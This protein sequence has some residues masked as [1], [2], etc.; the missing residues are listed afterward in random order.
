[1]RRAE[2]PGP[3]QGNELPD[4]AKFYIYDVEQIV[5]LISDV[6]CLTCKEKGF[7]NILAIDFEKNTT[8]IK[9]SNCTAIMTA[10]LT[11]SAKLVKK[12]RKVNQMYL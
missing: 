3:G 1:M 10:D 12:G 7:Y 5:R 11:P 8:K 9:C 6:E 2:R 4:F